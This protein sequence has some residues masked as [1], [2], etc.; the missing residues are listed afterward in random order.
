MQ[1]DLG[2]EE[3]GGRAGSKRQKLAAPAGQKQVEENLH[4]DAFEELT[5]TIRS[6]NGSAVI[7]SA[8]AETKLFVLFNAYETRQAMHP[9][10]CVYASYGQ[11][12]DATKSVKF[13]MVPGEKSWLVD[14]MLHQEGC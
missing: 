9:R 1:D 12:L 7:F 5:I 2:V 10:D 13:Y 14:A 3:T 6:Q 11:R 4:P 8:K